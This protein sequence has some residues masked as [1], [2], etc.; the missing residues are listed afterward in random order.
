[1]KEKCNHELEYLGS[2]KGEKG[3]NRYFRCKK[4]GCVIVRDDE[5][6]KF[7][8]PSGLEE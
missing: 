7:E 6:N 2:E 1:M 8:I 4:C 3:D 5:G